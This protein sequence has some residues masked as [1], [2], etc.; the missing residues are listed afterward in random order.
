MLTQ[1]FIFTFAIC[2]VLSGTL[3]A[4]GNSLSLDACLQQARAHSPVLAQQSL[5]REGLVARTK[6]LNR[7]YWPQLNANGQAT[8]QSEVINIPLE[9]P[10]VDLPTPPQDQYR[11]TLDLQQ[12]L[13]DGGVTQARKTQAEAQA[14]AT[15]RGLE[16]DF[17]QAERQIIQLYF[18]AM[19][20]DRQR[21]YAELLQT[22]LQRQI[23]RLEAAVENGIAVPSDVLQLRAKLLEVRQQ[24]QSAQH[25]KAAALA[26]LELWMGEAIAPETRL[27]PPE[28]EDLPTDIQRLELA[29]LD[30]H[31]EVIQASAALV[32]SADR[33]KLGAFASL[34]YGRPGLN[35]L[36]EDWNTY[37][38]L[39]ARI[40]LPLTWLY[41]GNQRLELQQLAV[42]RERLARQR[43]QFVL[44]TESARQGKYEEIIRLRSQVAADEE[45]IAIRERISAT[46]ATQLREGIITAS[47]YLTEL[48]REDLAQQNKL[49]H[50]IQLHQ[51]IA[52][53]R[54]LSGER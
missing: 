18:G 33:P 43:E 30:Q 46:A 35:L 48:N 36:S 45:I 14:A 24:Q 28:E 20:A 7:D 50:E 41:T 32:R 4:Q 44:Q 31:A 34:G 39:G 22:D 38:Q 26:A 49:L 51:A 52:D 47:D 8:W 3:A 40:S 54:W 15:S 9:F 16:V 25:Q 29:L 12:S 37:A 21:A 5:V 10:G 1:R 6:R 19:L 42:E 27:T 2:W 13:W 53:Y 23:N 11:L 17:Y